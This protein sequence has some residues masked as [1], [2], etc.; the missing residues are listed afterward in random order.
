MRARISVALVLLLDYKQEET[1]R[2]KIQITSRTQPH[3]PTPNLTNLILTLC[4]TLSK[5]LFTPGIKMHEQPETQH[6][7]HL[8]TYSTRISKA[9]SRRRT[10][11]FHYCA[12]SFHKWKLCAQLLQLLQLSLFLL[13]YI[14]V[15]DYYS[16]HQVSTAQM[17]IRDL[18][19]LPLQPPTY[20]FIRSSQ[21]VL[22][23][24]RSQSS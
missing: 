13:S 14:H 5:S 9:S 15:N 3:S 23:V 7:L 4:L 12:V 10:S 16:S 18:V 17:E 2:R 19:S 22:W 8:C 1:T 24:I 6:S 20:V 11:G 21:E